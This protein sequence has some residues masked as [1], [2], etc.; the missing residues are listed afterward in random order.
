MTV[1]QQGSIRQQLRQAVYD[2]RER[3]LTESAS[4]AAQQLIGLPKAE[5]DEMQE[6]APCTSDSAESDVFLYAK[7]L[8]DMKVCRVQLYTLA[9]HG[10]RFCGHAVQ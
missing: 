8:F 7:T 10:T 1:P 5:D 4:W 3:G 6:D 2:C 9:A